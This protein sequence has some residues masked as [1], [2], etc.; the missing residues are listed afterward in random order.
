MS[1]LPSSLEEVPTDPEGDAKPPGRL[2]SPLPLPLTRGLRTEMLG[3]GGR[4]GT[5]TGTVPEVGEQQCREQGQYWFFITRT[6]LT[7]QDY[8]VASWKTE[9]AITW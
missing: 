4:H 5:G 8:L 7:R 6:A 9:E 1:F 3:R 2:G